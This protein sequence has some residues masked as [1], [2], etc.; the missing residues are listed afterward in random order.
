MSFSER[1]KLK[2]LAIVHI[3]ETS[4]PL[5]DYGAVAVLNDG[6]GISYGIN[7]F[8]HRSGS[9]RLVLRRYKALDVSLRGNVHSIFDSYFDELNDSSPR[10]IDRLSRDTKLKQWLRE[11]GETDELMQQAQREIAFEKY[12]QPALDACEGSDFTLPLSLAVI[13]DSINHGS[14]GKIRDR[15]RIEPPGNGSMKPEEFEREWI[16]QYV[17]KRDAWLESVP[18]LRSTDYR[19]DFFLAQIARG[20]WQLD[21]PLNVHG[22]RLT[23]KDIVVADEGVRVP[24]SE[25]AELRPIPQEIQPEPL[26]TGELEELRNAVT[27]QAE[28]PFSK[29]EGGRM[30]D[31]GVPSQ[32]AENIVNVSENS[33][34]RENF[35]PEDKTVDAPPPTGFLA[36]LK[37]HIA[38]LGIG[39]GTFTAVKELT[40][41]QLGA[42][43]VEL[44]KI[45]IPTLL[46]L[47]FIGFLVWYV[48]EK[49]VG[50]KTLKLQSEINTDPNRHNL[51]INPQ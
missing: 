43:T 10:S 36:K 37:F 14:Y 16:T 7:Q 42:E 45:V 46:G 6:A 8:T 9:L 1:D 31:E 18:R 22:Y 24:V 4:K 19:T 47:G 40:G 28:A 12:M 38:T 50:S 33:P 20:N 3:F 13:Y 44:L 11:L 25:T 41:L 51:K 2:A 30:K 34:V 5:G 27:P 17:K 35:V 39:T 15:V 29:D 48:T 49:V 21:L 26:Q 23:E 32:T